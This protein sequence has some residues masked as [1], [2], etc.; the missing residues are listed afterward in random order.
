MTND[1]NLAI[2]KC[3]ACGYIGNMKLW[4]EHYKFGMKVVMWI[5]MHIFVSLL[6][7]SLL[8]PWKMYRCPQCRM[9]GKNET[10]KE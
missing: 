6:L 8:N 1:Y 4:H 10:Y 5:L 3:S 7:R 9:I 2:R